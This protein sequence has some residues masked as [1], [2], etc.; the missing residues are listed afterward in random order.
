MPSRSTSSKGKALPSKKGSATSAD[1]N[2]SGDKPQT[3][4]SEP[5]E[6]GVNGTEDVEMADDAV[7]R[8]KAGGAKEGEDEMTVVV[9]PPKSSK[10]SGDPGR[11]LEGDIAMDSTEKPETDE[12]EPEE[13]DPQVK[14][15]SG[16][17]STLIRNNMTF[18]LVSKYH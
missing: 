16:Q 14:A 5:A 17:Y 6:N 15:I 7:A 11:D 18:C 3:N 9:P 1:K 2:M 13:V 10:L 4:G 8:A 12:P